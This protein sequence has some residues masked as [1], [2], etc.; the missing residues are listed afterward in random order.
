MALP[1]SKETSRMKNSSGVL[2]MDRVLESSVRIF[3]ALL[4]R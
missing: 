2:K 4:L 1:F 3:L